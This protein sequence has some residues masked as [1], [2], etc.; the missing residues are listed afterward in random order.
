MILPVATYEEASRA[1]LDAIAQG[2]P[3]TLLTVTG[4]AIS[5]DEADNYDVRPTET[6][7]WGQRRPS[8][9]TWR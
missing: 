8:C 3:Q 5:G 6:E 7:H 9:S 2:L 4:G 1:I